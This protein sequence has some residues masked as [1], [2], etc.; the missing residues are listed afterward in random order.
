MA[1]P[2]VT[3]GVKLCWCLRVLCL[4]LPPIEVVCPS[5]TMQWQGP[6]EGLTFY[7]SLVKEDGTDLFRFVLFIYF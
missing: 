6:A 3:L 5:Y 7:Q 1:V 2:R 4:H